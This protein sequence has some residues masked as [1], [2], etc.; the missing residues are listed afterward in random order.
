MIEYRLTAQGITASMLTGFFQGWTSP[1][2][3]EE[4]RRILGNSEHIVLAVDTDSGR[5][6]GFRL[7]IQHGVWV[8]L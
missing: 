2:T 5:V 8:N 1:R 4:H 7:S 6:V 3:P